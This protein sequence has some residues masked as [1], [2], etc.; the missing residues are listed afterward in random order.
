MCVC[1]AFDVPRWNCGL[2]YEEEQ[3]GQVLCEH[4]RAVIAAEPAVSTR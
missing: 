1:G 4:T 2:D 3:L